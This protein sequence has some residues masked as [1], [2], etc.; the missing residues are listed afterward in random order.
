MAALSL[1]CRLSDHGVIIEHVDHCVVVGPHD[2]ARM[3]ARP[4][5]QAQACLIPKQELHAVGSLGP[6]HVDDARQTGIKA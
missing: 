1:I 5:Q 3:H 2:P 4:I 6:E